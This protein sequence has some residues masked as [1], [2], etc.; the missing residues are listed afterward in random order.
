M[1]KFEIQK[2]VSFTHPNA[3]ILGK[4]DIIKSCV[5]APDQTLNV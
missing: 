4:C 3:Q 5:E 1:C 2:K